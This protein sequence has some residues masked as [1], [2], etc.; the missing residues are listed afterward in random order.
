MQIEILDLHKEI[1][2]MSNAEREEGL[3]ECREAEIMW[4]KK[5]RFFN[6]ML[7]FLLDVTS[8]RGYFVIWH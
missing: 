4:I 6:V 3:I 7:Y 8:I 2:I 1:G 5:E